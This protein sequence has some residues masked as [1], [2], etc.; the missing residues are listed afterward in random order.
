MKMWNTEVQGLRLRYSSVRH[1]CSRVVP[2]RFKLYSQIKCIRLFCIFW[3]IYIYIP[4]LLQ[5]LRMRSVVRC[6]RASL[7]HN[8]I[9]LSWSLSHRFMKRNK[10][11]EVTT[12]AD[13]GFRQAQN[14]SCRRHVVS[15]FSSYFFSLSFP[16]SRLFLFPLSCCSMKFPANLQPVVLNRASMK[17]LRFMVIRFHPK[18]I[19]IFAIEKIP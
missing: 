8:I 17:F 4:A 3:G 2:C 19:P 13:K 1:M 5:P 16:P 7:Y 10:L 6:G 9:F 15:R 12:L 11:W 14:S 18:W